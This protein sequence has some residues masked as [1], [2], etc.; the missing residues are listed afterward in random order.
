MRRRTRR[1]RRRNPESRRTRRRAAMSGWRSRKR[2]PIRRHRRRR[3]P[4]SLRTRRRAAR[5]GARHRRRNPLFRSR[6]RHHRRHRNPFGRQGNEIMSMLVPA[7][8]GAVSAVALD[9]IV[10]YLP[11]PATVATGWGS[12]AVKAVG[13]VG[14]GFLAGM[15]AGKRNGVLVGAGA[16]T[17][18]GYDAVKAALA[19]TLGTTIK[20]LS[21]LADF[22]DYTSMGAY[23]Q[24][25]QPLGAYMNP[26]SFVA[27]P[28]ALSAPAASHPAAQAANSLRIKQMAGAGL[29]GFGAQEF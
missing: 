28:P 10:A 17:V 7:G 11:L 6:R 16:L 21:G 5:M 8:I 2:N 1:H 20:G 4:E 3:N 15:V 23:M 18:V 25:G 29:S 12:I 27:G 9:V 19:P 26:G 14:L 22:G 13:A 24:S